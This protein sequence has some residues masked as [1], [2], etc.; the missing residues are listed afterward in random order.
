MIEYMLNAWCRC[1]MMLS[2]LSALLPRYAF[3]MLLQQR[4]QF[5]ADAQKRAGWLLAG[6][7][8]NSCSM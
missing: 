4:G 2:V 5:Q 1:F 8:V 7:E 6:V 3:S